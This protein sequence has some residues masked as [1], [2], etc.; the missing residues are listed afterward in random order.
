LHGG[1]DAPHAHAMQVNEDHLNPC[2]HMGADYSHVHQDTH[3]KLWNFVRENF[4]KRFTKGYAKDEASES[5]VYASQLRVDAQVLPWTSNEQLSI[6]HW[7][8]LRFE[9]FEY[10]HKH[11]FAGHFGAQR[12]LKKLICFISGLIWLW[13]SSL[14]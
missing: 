8:Y 13:T 7:D 9:G 6:P 10:V 12:T 14:G 11:P 1:S 4:C 2:T 5:A 3:Y